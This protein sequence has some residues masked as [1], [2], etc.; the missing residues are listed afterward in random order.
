LAEKVFAAEQRM[1]KRLVGDDFKRIDL[2]YVVRPGAGRT[3]EAGPGG[4][5]FGAPDIAAYYRNAADRRLVITG[6][7]GAGKT[8]LALEL[9]LALIK[10]P[11]PGKPRQPDD[12]VPVRLSLS[13]WDTEISV[14]RNLI[15]HL[16]RT[17]D[18]RRRHAR[19]LVEQRRVLPVLDGLDEMDPLRS[20][21]RPDPKAPKA[22]A[23]LAALNDYQDGLQ[24]GPVIVTC[25]TAHYDALTKSSPGQGLR[26]ATR[27]DITPISPTNARAYLE[28]RADDQGRWEPLLDALRDDPGGPLARTLSTPWR[29][30]LAATV[31]YEHGDPADMLRIPTERELDEHLLAR[32]VPAATRL[33]PRRGHTP[34]RV[35]RWLHFLTAHR[36]DARTPT[37]DISLA[38]LWPLAGRERVRSVDARLAAVFCMLWLLPNLQWGGDVSAVLI[39]QAPFLIMGAGFAIGGAL[40]EDIQPVRRRWRHLHVSARRRVTVGYLTATAL[41]GVADAIIKTAALHSPARGV[42]NGLA[43]TFVFWLFYWVAVA[44][45]LRLLPKITRPADVINDDLSSHLAVVVAGWF[46]FALRT[47]DMGRG[48]PTYLL[49]YSYICITTAHFYIGSPGRRYLAFILITYRRHQLPLR[50]KAFLDWACEAGLMRLSGTAYQFRHLELQQWVA[51]HADGSAAPRPTAALP[52]RRRSSPAA[53]GRHEG[54]DLFPRRR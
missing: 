40:K 49:L 16:T 34:E 29:L 42:L 35:H 33:H 46:M 7:A 10:P 11:E 19:E 15:G 41:L 52:A 9:I 12:P 5:L 27:I 21:G 18:M 39:A 32:C 20:R 51:A 25:R 14:E 24:A 53:P 47:F 2:S 17:F 54:D 43:S 38:N 30:C 28:R 37:I 8:V 22:R 4:R 44:P 31:Y 23:V 48:I 50:L 26:D 45:L 36:T 1:W 3:G 6:E 13:Q